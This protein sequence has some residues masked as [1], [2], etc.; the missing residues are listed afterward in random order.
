MSTRDRSLTFPIE[1]FAAILS[2]ADQT[3]LAAAC[4]CSLALLQLAGPLLYFEVELTTW[5]S[6]QAFFC[7]TVSLALRRRASL[8]R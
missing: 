8:V 7:S 6:F 2:F 1:I 3:T 5:S 4:R